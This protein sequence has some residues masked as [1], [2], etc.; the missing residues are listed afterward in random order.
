LT[1]G[2]LYFIKTE[3]PGGELNQLNIRSD[4]RGLIYVD[5][6]NNKNQRLAIGNN[7]NFRGAIHMMGKGAFEMNNG[8][9]A[10]LNITHD[11]S[12]L[13]GFGIPRDGDG[14]SETVD[15]NQPPTVTVPVGQTITFIAT[16][17]YFY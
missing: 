6:A 4:F 9:N 7:I 3:Y 15:P 14:D 8:G 1:A 13:T 5:P 11:P 16:G 12:I 10:T 2:T 17:Y